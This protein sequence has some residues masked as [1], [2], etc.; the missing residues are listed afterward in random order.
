MKSEKRF[1]GSVCESVLVQICRQLTVTSHLRNITIHP[2]NVIVL[3][4]FQVRLFEVIDKKNKD[5]I[6]RRLFFYSRIE[7]GPIDKKGDMQNTMEIRIAQ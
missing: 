4:D 3:E 7:S 2:Y 5:W 1:S 6:Q